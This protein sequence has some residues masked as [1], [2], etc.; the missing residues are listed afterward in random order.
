M[1]SPSKEE[2]ENEEKKVDTSITGQSNVTEDVEESQPD[3]PKFTY[4]I[5]K[6]DAVSA[7]KNMF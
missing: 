6:R 1:E 7:M 3:G 4:K 2:I 5:P